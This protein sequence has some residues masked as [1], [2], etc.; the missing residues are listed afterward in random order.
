MSH[1]DKKRSKIAAEAARRLVRGGDIHRARLGA[2]RRLSREWVPADELPSSSDITRELSRQRLVDDED[3]S[4][5]L[6]SLIGDRFDKIAALVRPLSA[7]RLDTSRPHTITLLE[8]T[9]L[10]FAYVEKQQPFDEELLTAALL[11][12][13]GRIINRR[14]ATQAI[15]QAANGLVTSRTA[16]LVEARDVATA[17]TN[18]TLGHRA[19]H[20]LTVHADSDHA[21][22]LSEA[23]RANQQEDVGTLSLDDAIERLRSLSASC[24]E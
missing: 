12:D 22:L 23:T 18:G 16:W 3:C 5:G 15:L 11:V 6:V 20:R 17:Y 9:L 10:S 13:A 1:R 2:A 19:R 4:G 21:M 8:A 14:N 7:M 24:D